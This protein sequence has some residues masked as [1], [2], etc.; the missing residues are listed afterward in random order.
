MDRAYLKIV[1]ELQQLGLEVRWEIETVKIVMPKV[2]TS[3]YVYSKVCLFFFLSPP[4]QVARRAPM[5]RFPSVCDKNSYYIIGHSWKGIV[6]S[7]ME[8]GQNLVDVW[9][10]K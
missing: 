5:R 1:E 2:G 10:N 8:I 7:Q 4:V 9:G 3:K 6:G